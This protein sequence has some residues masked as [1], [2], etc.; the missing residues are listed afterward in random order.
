M[1]SANTKKTIDL[2]LPSAAAGF[3]AWYVFGRS[4]DWRYVA[5]AAAITWVLAYAITS[6]ITKAVHVKGPAPVPTGGGC[7]E[8]SPVALIDAIHEDTTC[9]FCFR[10]RDLYDQLLGLA[11]CQF[12]KAYNYWNEK[13]YTETSKSLAVTVSEQSSLFDSRFQQQ[14]SAL[15][16]KFATLNLQ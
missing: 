6:Q 11:D 12:I 5:A 3:V 8:Y 9:T 1:L 13:Y 4:K 7:E 10:N 14:Q 16:N 2:V 15:K